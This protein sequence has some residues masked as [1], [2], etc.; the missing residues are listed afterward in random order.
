M[1]KLSQYQPN[2]LTVPSAILV[3]LSQKWIKVPKKTAESFAEMAK[4]VKVGYFL[5]L[6]VVSK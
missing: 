4:T 3:K 1:S 2:L 5:F 6:L